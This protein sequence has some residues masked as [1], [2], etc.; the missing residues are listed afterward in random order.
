VR[1]VRDGTYSDVALEY[2]DPVRHPTSANFREASRALMRPWLRQ[3]ATPAASVLETGAGDSIV[4]EWM[5]KERRTVARFVA[6]DLSLEMLRYSRQR[7]GGT[8]LVVCDAQ[9]LPLADGAFDL[10]AA[11]LA[12]PYNT[13]LFWREAAR[14]L[15]PGGHVLF[16]SPS[17]E[18]AQRFRGGAR[19]AEFVR[20]DGEVLMLPSNVDTDNAQRD[21]IGACGLEVL[22]AEFVT[23]TEL[24]ETVRSPKLRSGSIVSGYLA[25]RPR[26]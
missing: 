17:F 22:R 3:Y 6:S 9:R 19:I 25:R 1:G 26:E 5:Q 11:S 24:H 16:T 4:G 18:W 7:K 13:S 2:Y 10:V 23:D 8:N 21:L 12:D 14:V 15:R 20:A